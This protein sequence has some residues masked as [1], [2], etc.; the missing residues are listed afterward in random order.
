[1]LKK[2]VKRET[3]LPKIAA[4]KSSGRLKE[5]ELSAGGTAEYAI[6][7]SQ[8]DSPYDSQCGRE[9][10]NEL[11]NSR[12]KAPKIRYVPVV[13][14]NNKPLMPTS[15]ARARKWVKSGKGTWF[16]HFGIYCIRL[17]EE[18]SAKNSHNICVEIGRASC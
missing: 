11:P 3:T 5:T 6:D 10:V 4:V 13:D 1:M 14:K 16:W 7:A 12:L 15:A 2:R 8:V 18:P 17:N 9:V